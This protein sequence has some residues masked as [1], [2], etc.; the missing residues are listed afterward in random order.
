MVVLIV[1]L[2]SIIFLLYVI[3]YSKS[4]EFC[5]QYPLVWI[6][7][8]VQWLSS[9]GLEIYHTKE[10]YDRSIYG[11]MRI[12]IMVIGQPVIDILC[13][14]IVFIC[15]HKCRDSPEI[16]KTAYYVTII[17]F[18]WSLLRQLIM[19]SFFIFVDVV[20]PISTIGIVAFGVI[21][22]VMWSYLSKGVYKKVLTIDTS[23]IKLPLLI[24]FGLIDIFV[25]FSINAITYFVIMVYITFLNSLPKSPEDIL[26]KLVC[27]FI[28]PLLA[29]GFTF[30]LKWWAPQNE[31]AP[32]TPD[33]V[34][35]RRDGYEQV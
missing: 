22:T 8:T 3:P 25:Y 5:E 34:G 26:L 4:D 2:V 32:E 1:S 7:F 30:G 18:G 29:A 28:P 16:L 10:T 11:K 24:I 15:V 27:A 6:G 9:I 21:F 31:T 17:T 33:P 23:Y 19:L 13:M 12:S 14:I 35:Q 20:E